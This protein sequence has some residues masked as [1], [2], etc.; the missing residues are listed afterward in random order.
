MAMADG[1]APPPAGAPHPASPPPVGNTATG[2]P[3][4]VVIGILALVVCLVLISIVAKYFPIDC[5]NLGLM[6][7][8]YPLLFG[9]AGV[10]LGGSIGGDGRIVF[11]GLPWN[12]RVSGGIA[13]MVLGAAYVAST[14][15]SSP[16]DC[17]P[18]R[19]LV[20]R[21]WLSTPP[22]PDQTIFPNHFVS[23]DHQSD[24]DIRQSD[25]SMILT[26]PENKEFNFTARFF[27]KVADDTYRLLTVCRISVSHNQAPPSPTTTAA[28][29]RLQETQSTE[30]E[31]RLKF[32]RTYLKTL[33]EAGN[34]GAAED[35]RNL[36]LSGHFSRDGRDYETEV[37][38]AVVIVGPGT[39]DK[40]T[41]FPSQPKLAVYFT[42]ANPLPNSPQ[43]Q[44]TRAIA[45]ATPVASGEVQTPAGTGANAAP[46]PSLPAAAAERKPEAPRPP[47]V[48]GCVP[49]ADL[50]DALDRFLQGEDFERTQRDAFYARWREIQCY[51]RPLATGSGDQTVAAPMRA[52]ALRLLTN[53]IINN[54][55][56]PG[57]NGKYW[58]PT[59]PNKRDFGLPLPHVSASD[60]RAIFALIPSDE[61]VLRAEALRFVK[62]VPV[63]ALELLFREKAAATAALSLRQR[64][65]YAIAASFMYYGRIVEWLDVP[66]LPPPDKAPIQQAVTADWTQS[67]TWTRDALFEGKS[68]KPYEAMLLYAKAIVEREAPLTPDRGGAT[69]KAMLDAIQSTGDA[70]PS[71]HLHIAQAVA[72]TFGRD[73]TSTLEILRALPA[74]DNYPPATMM[75]PSRGFTAPSYALY[76]GPDRKYPALPAQVSNGEGARLLLRIG[77]WHL[78][79]ARGKVGWILRA[80]GT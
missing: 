30:R 47:V 17:A 58:Q 38:G 33:D 21:D 24:V 29:Y 9:A 22:D 62:T 4:D 77:D 27:R 78:I 61:D 37:P 80:T 49:P 46:S 79:S 34:N 14:A 41:S 51:V 75:D 48:A 28:I 70:Y 45:Q 2:R 42:K 15:I 8:V 66:S 52:R 63:D 3:F 7:L 57:D 72:I 60:L 65:R 18:K 74:A 50:R 40:A 68:A 26:F 69:F 56:M 64:E 10:V 53:T 59:G 32:N 44:A 43:P 67:R 23:I 55:E 12:M 25:G 71:N 20:I 16:V 6:K 1:G 13:G 5:G 35:Y 54:S 19:A 39:V 73:P 36:C 11:L 76:A 31:I